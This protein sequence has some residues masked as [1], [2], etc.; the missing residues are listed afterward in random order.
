MDTETLQA[1]LKHFGYY[2][3]RV[4]GIKNRELDIALR[5]FQKDANLLSLGELDEE[6]LKK[7]NKLKEQWELDESLAYTE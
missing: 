2:K 7:L 6:T 1:V 3:A 5:Q 4:D